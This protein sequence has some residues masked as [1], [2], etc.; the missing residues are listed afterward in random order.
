VHKGEIGVNRGCKLIGISKNA[1]YNS[2]SPMERLNK[3][4]SH[5][6]PCIQN[7]IK[8]NPAYGYRRI[9][10]ELYNKYKIVINHKLLKKLLKMWGLELKRKRKK[11]KKKWIQVILEFLQSRANLVRKMIIDGKLR[12][13][14]QV[15]VS[16]IT[17]I[18]YNGQKAY[19]CVHMDYIGKMIYGWSLS[20]TSDYS[21]V[22]KSFIKAKDKIRKFNQKTAGIIFHQDRGSVYTGN[23]YIS[24]ILKH[25]GFLS[26]SKAGKPGDN[27]VNEAFFSR[28]KEEWGD[29]FLEAKDFKELSRIIKCKIDYYNQRRLHSSIDYNTPFNFTKLFVSDLT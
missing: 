9:K 29:L 18:Y 3:K 19:L 6:K 21:L 15:I 28:L 13:C 1:Y 12:S 8:N 11:G 26:Y 22:K 17:E 27:A 24:L 14:F 7:I 4:Y 25:K 20:K 5:I 10:E 2:C 23:N 16:D